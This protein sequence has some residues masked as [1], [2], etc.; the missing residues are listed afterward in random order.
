MAL[1]ISRESCDL[2]NTPSCYKTL[3][4]GTEIPHLLV[5]CSLVLPTHYGLLG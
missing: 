2:E 5:H 4:E 3:W 1:Q